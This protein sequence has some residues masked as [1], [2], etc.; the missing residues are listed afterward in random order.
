MRSVKSDG[1]VKLEI[2]VENEDNDYRIVFFKNYEKYSNAMRDIP[3]LKK[4]YALH[5]KNYQI[6]ITIIRY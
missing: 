4:K 6:F 3:S 5:N 2:E 1:R